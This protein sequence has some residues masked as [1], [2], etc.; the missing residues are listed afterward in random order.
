MNHKGTIQLETDR[1]ILRRFQL[2]D[3]EAMLHNC[4][5]DF[6][7]WKW[8]SY[9]EMTSL[10][11]IV[12]KNGLFTPWWM[13]L[14]ANSNRYNW[15]II[16]RSTNQPIGRVFVMN[17]NEDSSELEITYEIGKNWWNQGLMTEALK[18]IIRFLFT[19]VLVK[20]IIA[21]HAKENPA[22][23]KVMKNLGM[24][25]FKIVPDGYTCNAGTF[26]SYYYEIFSE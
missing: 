3:A 7:V 20:R 19:E 6:D 26:D 18:E 14:Y 13:G 2:G 16:L 4:W 5:S 8:T 25:P 24:K 1:L 12:V 21:Y 11:D 22:S 9:D 23:G 17:L 15:A 10:D